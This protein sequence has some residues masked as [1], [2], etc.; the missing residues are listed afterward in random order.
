MIKKYDH[1]EK[2]SEQNGDLPNGLVVFALAW[3]LSYLSGAAG[4]VHL[5]SPVTHWDSFESHDGGEREG[6]ATHEEGWGW[7]RGWEESAP[8]SFRFLAVLR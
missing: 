8:P 2:S 7:G 6:R 5:H 3:R 1:S 4:P